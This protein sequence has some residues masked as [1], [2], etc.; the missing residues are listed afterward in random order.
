MV[1]TDY[2]VFQTLSIT[3]GSSAYRRDTAVSVTV[4]DHE[5]PY[6]VPERYAA[7]ERLDAGEYR[8]VLVR[9]SDGAVFVYSF[10]VRP[11]TVVIRDER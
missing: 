3:E 5:G 6:D 4:N 7:Q 1:G 8:I 9:P 11:L 10:T 2:L